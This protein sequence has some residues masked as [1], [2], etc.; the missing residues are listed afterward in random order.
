MRGLA[1]VLFLA[2]ARLGLWWR[3]LGGAA[4][5]GGGGAVGPGEGLWVCVEGPCSHG[6]GGG[7]FGDGEKRGSGGG[8]MAGSARLGRAAL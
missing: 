2:G 6:G 8:A 4:L 1:A 7:G 3:G 5:S